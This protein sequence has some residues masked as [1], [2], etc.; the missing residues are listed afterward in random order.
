[1]PP[2]QLSITNHTGARN[3]G[4]EAL[5]QS[6]LTG[7]AAQCD[8]LHT[9]LHS[10]DPL[11]DRWR[12][13]DHPKLRVLWGY[14]LLTPNHSAHPWVNRLAYTLARHGETLLPRLRGIS[15]QSLQTLRRADLVVASGGD[16]FTSDYANLRKHLAYPLNAPRRGKRRALYLCSHSIG[17][18]NAADRDAFLRIAEQI[19]LITVREPLSYHYLTHQL[20]LPTRVELTADVAFTLASAPPEPTR[21]QLQHH[22]GLNLEKPIIALSISQGI[23]H[24]SGLDPQHYYQT[25]AQFCDQQL[26]H[27]AQLL[28]IPHVIE[29]NP[30][31]NDQIACQQVIQRIRAPGPVRLIAGEPSASELKAIIG[32]CQLLVGARTHATIAAMSQGVPTVSLAYSRKASGIMQQVYGE[33]LGQ[34]L[35]LSAAQLS[36]QALQDAVEHSQAHPISPAHLAQLKQ[37]AQRNFTLLNELLP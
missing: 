7:F 26:E 27:G 36:P 30:N 17:P 6:M 10:S 21:Q 16:I 12:F 33:Q 14:P 20:Q 5:V 29:R 3:R 9:T 11:Y 1:M 4:C 23:I 37:Q 31:N 35:T 15:T 32:Q 24:Y 34:A 28:F 2:I 19:A 18:F 25:L 8:Q 22:Y 13:A